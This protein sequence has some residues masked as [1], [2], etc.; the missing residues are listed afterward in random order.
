MLDGAWGT[1]IHG[2]GLGPADYRGERFAAHPRDVAGDPDILNLTRPDFV[3]VG[4]R[5]YFAAGRRHHDHEHLHG[6]VDR[7]G[8]L[9]RSRTRST[10]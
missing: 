1:L 5:A 2:R 3:R 9:R 4:P 6:D 7:P 8:R 10:R